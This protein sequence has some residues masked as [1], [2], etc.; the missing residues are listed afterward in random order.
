MSADNHVI[1]TDRW[2]HEITATL[3][4]MSDR[5][6]ALEAFEKMASAMKRSWK[7]GTVDRLSE[8]FPITNEDINVLLQRQLTY[9]RARARY[10]VR[11]TPYGQAAVNTIVNYVVGVGFDLQM[12]LRRFRRGPNGPERMD[13]TAFNDFIQD[14]WADWSTS[15]NVQASD[16]A[17]D[18]LYDVQEMI[19]RNWFTDGEFFIHMPLDRSRDVVPMGLE[20]VDADSIGCMHSEW[21]GNPIV[22]GVELDK[23]SWKPVAYWCYQTAD[24]HPSY[25][26][27]MHAARI[28]AEEMIHVYTRILPRQIRGVPFMASVLNKV[29]NLEDYDNAVM[30]QSKIATMLSA[31]VIGGDPKSILKYGAAGDTTSSSGFPVDSD[32]NVIANLAP[33]L[34]GWLPEGHDMKVTSPTSPHTSYNEFLHT[35]SSA[36]GAGIEVGLSYTA[37][38]RDTSGT[39]F[40]SGRHAE[41]MDMQGWRRMQGKFSRKAMSPVFRRWMDLAVL[42]GAVDLSGYE[43]DP[44][45][46][47]R[48]HWMPGGWDRGINPL[49]TAQASEKWMSLGISTLADECS[50]LGLDWKGQVRKAV[51]IA[52]ERARGDFEVVKYMKDTLGMTVE[53]VELLKAINEARKARAD[54][55]AG[56]SP[57]E[58]ELAQE[59]CN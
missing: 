35:Q 47:Q 21:Q 3:S 46:W 32:G 31:F 22:M 9:L 24:T 34:I 42:S 2:G 45:P 15:V 44:R 39:T 53:D 58:T 7:G 12:D 18:H 28:P 30:V 25:P 59:L 29:F 38:T 49:Q 20:L 52:K 6:R 26:T 57:A 19:M 37:L 16:S 41:N 23:R 40:A 11:N 4:S 8:N 43:V 48:H 55:P 33:G 27:K 50:M 51:E 14:L 36:I 5:S 1:V 56:R 54:V 10:V 17:P 13:M